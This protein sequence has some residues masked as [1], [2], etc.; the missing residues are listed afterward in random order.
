M[1]NS[2]FARTLSSVHQLLHKLLFRSIK[3][4]NL[5]L[6]EVDSVCIRKR[7]ISVDDKTN[8][9]LVYIL[10]SVVISVVIDLLLNDEI[11]RDFLSMSHI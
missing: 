2:P 6:P 10:C 8:V 11:E 9:S 3:H 7:T 1:P 4:V 5:R